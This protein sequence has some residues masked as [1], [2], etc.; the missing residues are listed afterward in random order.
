VPT[1]ITRE[2]VSGLVQ[3][4]AA[5]VDVLPKREYEQEHLPGARS[6]P[7]GDLNRESTRELPRER[8]IV[9]YCQDQR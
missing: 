4:G 9:V 1:D 6:V 3:Q 8:A 2:R 5:L 7:L